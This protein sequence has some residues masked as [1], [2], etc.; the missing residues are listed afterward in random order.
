MKRLKYLATGI[1]ALAL[2]G[3][4]Q[5]VVETLN[6][7]VEAGADAKGRGMTAVILPFA[8]YS[9]G[10]S[11]SS[12]HRRNL[13]V[14]ESITDRLVANGFGIPV[15]EDVFFY[16]VDQDIISLMP[17]DNAGKTSLSDELGNDWSPGMKAEI[18][19]YIN[20]QRATRH[21]KVADSPGTHGLDTKAVAKIGRRF[22]ADYVI[23]GRILEYKTRQEATWAPWKRGILPFIT[24]TTSHMFYGFAGSAQYDEWGMMTAGAAIGALAGHGANYPYENYN[25]IRG[26][27]ADN[28]VVWGAIGAGLGKMSYNSGKVDQAAVQLRIWVQEAATGNVVWTNR[29][30]VQVSPETVFSDAQYDTLFNQAIEKGVGT[31]IDN[32]VNTTL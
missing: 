12:A 13:K 5:T 4:G 21:N 15:Q 26:S 11:I 9:Y 17:Y 18:Q 25:F 23:R 14:T 10:D 2:T 29:V 16:L 22:N 28:D 3:C 24:G 7:P 20:I 19:K 8:D 1:L 30:R 32:F 27:V 6:V 31:L